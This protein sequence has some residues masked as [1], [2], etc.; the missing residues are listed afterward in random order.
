VLRITIHNHS[1]QARL[2]VEGRLTKDSAPELE[3]CWREATPPIRVEL[4]DVTFVD[5]AGRR[6]LEAM[7]TAGVELTTADV[8]MKSIVEEI[9]DRKSR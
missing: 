3:R 5:D 2:I 1:R 9:E 4:N 7:A 8:A 6:L